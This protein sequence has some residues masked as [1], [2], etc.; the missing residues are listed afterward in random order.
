MEDAPIIDGGILKQLQ[1]AVPA[2][3]AAGDALTTRIKDFEIWLGRVPGRVATSC[4]LSTHPD[5]PDWVTRLGFFRDGKEWSLYLYDFC[6]GMDEV[7]NRRLLRDASIAEKTEAIR[8]FP[9][10]LKGMVTSQQSLVQWANRAVG[11]F[12]AFAKSIGMKE[13]E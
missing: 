13:G 10:L 6:E 3:R 4:D 1:D 11:D 12:D 5:D 9:Q 2:V 7:R 8:Q